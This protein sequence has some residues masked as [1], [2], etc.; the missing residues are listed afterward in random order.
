MATV[1]AAV[2]NF[3]GGD[4]GIF[5]TGLDGAP[6]GLRAVGRSFV[7]LGAKQEFVAFALPRHHLTVGEFAAVDAGSRRSG[8]VACGDQ[9][10]ATEQ[11]VVDDNIPVVF[12]VTHTEETRAHRGFFLRDDGGFFFFLLA[13]ARRLR[14]QCGGKGEE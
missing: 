8:D 13:G 14:K 11:G 4:D 5:G 10:G 3:E 9:H 12:F 2:L 7:H 1:A 6:N